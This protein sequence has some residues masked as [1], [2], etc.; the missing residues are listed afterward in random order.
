MD[1]VCSVC[2]H[3]VGIPR[4]SKPIE[5]VSLTDEIE[6]IINQL[7]IN[8]DMLGRQ[9]II[10]AI[11]IVATSSKSQI[12]PYRDVY[13]IIGRNHSKSVDS[14]NRAIENALNKAWV[15][16]DPDILNEV[17]PRLVDST[18]GSPTNK[19]FIFYYANLVKKA[20]KA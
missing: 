2:K 10:E 11:E 12:K 19:E 5:P 8:E 7:R 6:N 16:T 4:R 3:H 15:T 14:V 18:K 20:H 1:L 13:P 9:F 17:Y